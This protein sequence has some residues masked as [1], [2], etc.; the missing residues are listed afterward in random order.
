MLIHGRGKHNIVK[1]LS[2]NKKGKKNGG[3]ISK[4]PRCVL[5]EYWKEKGTEHKKDLR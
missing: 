5:L 1:Q 4:G 2:P 3:T